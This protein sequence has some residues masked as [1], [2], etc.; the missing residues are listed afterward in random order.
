MTNFFRESLIRLHGAVGDA[1]FLT[2]SAAITFVLCIVLIPRTTDWMVNAS[3][4]LAGRHFGRHSRTLVINCSTNNPELFAMIIA[5]FLGRLGGIANPLGSNF[6]NIYL[7]FF[8]A[9]FIVTFWWMVTGRLSKSV[10]LGRL[11]WREKRLWFWH[12]IAASLMFLAAT[13]GYWSLT[14]AD[15]FRILGEPS[16]ADRGPVWLF[17]TA[18]ICALSLFVF[19]YFERRLKRGR[20]ELFED[21]DETDHVESWPLFFAGTGG[22][23]AACYLMNCLFLVWGDLYHHQLSLVLGPAVFT[24]LHFF[25]GSLITS[26]PETSVA[27]R[28]YRYCT[29]ADLNTALGSASY[30]NM[31]N[32]AIAA[33]G[34]LVAGILLLLGFNL[35]L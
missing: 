8:V 10:A 29:P 25:L 12:F 11:I 27:I 4:G 14:G 18:G 22:L 17:V 21:I 24:A 5:F 30:S 23:V 28:N 2:I 32:L 26:L 9:L 20:P 16:E 19:F 31:S 3:A 13:A 7:M 33:L 6:A 15:Q 35:S 1:W 34:A